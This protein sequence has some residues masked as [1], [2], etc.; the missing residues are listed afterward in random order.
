MREEAKPNLRF[1][2]PEEAWL[3]FFDTMI[4]ISFQIEILL[5]NALFIDG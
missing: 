2:I 1:S 4:A 3:V 5:E